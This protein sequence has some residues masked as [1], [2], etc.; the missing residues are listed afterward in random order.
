MSGNKKTAAA[1]RTK[2]REVK[3]SKESREKLK[4]PV[5]F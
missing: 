4:G 1:R 2:S 5:P 3:L